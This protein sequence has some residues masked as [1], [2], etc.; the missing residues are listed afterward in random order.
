MKGIEFT[1]MDI[2][3]LIVI[4]AV[5]DGKRTGKEASDKLN[6]SERQIWRLVK[7][8]RENGPE[9]IKHKNCFIKQPRFITP[10]LKEHIK[11][12]KLSD[13]YCDTNFTHFLELLEERENIKISYTSLYKILT[14]YGIKSKKKHRN[15]NTHR[16]RKRKAHEGD[17]V[18]ADG[19]PFD[20]FKDGHMYSIHGFI[21]D[22]TGKVL[23][24]YMCE[25]ECL[26]GYLET[27]RQMLKDY[28]IPK[29]LYPDK[30]SVF[31]PVKAQKLTI[32]EQL[33]GKTK[34]TTQF[35]RIIDV[36]GIDMF[37]AATSQAKG[38]IERLWNTFQDRLVTEFKLAEIKTI[39][40]ANEFLKSYLKKYNKKFAV[41]AE[42]DESNFVP[43]PTYLDLKLLLAIKITRTIDNSGSFTI[44]NKKFQILNNNIMPKSKINVYI[45][46]KIGIIA[47]YNNT[48]YKVICSDNLPSKYSTLSMNEF[49]KEHYQELLS[50][51]LSLLTY[52]AKEKE[53]LLVTS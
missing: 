48:K 21:D 50:F 27:L 15:R 12:L 3:K 24:A 22:A 40:E 52:N 13:D 30:F 28:G 38:R 33:Q 39:D 19:T 47:E 36:L 8:V 4:Q 10:E 45:S 5:I 49:Y 29:C 23:G 14:E 34:P 11:N 42:S 44:K 6:L 26:L 9:G 37:P 32:E 35:K 51:A 1:E 16:Q 25:H 2:E 46:K 18:Q 7:K 53:P 17:L 41:K 31:F 20:W 43:V